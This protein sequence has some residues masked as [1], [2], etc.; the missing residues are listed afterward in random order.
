MHSA[1]YIAT[2]AMEKLKKKVFVGL[3]GGV[4][5]AVS[6]ALLKKDGYDVV[7]VFI[8][9]WSPDWLPCT[10]RED[11][12]D[13][14]RVA[15]VLNI[16]F[17]TLDLE[18]EYKEGV[19]DYMVSE[20]EAGRVPNPDVMCNKSVKFGAFLNFALKNGADLVATGHYAR[21]VKSQKVSACRQAGKV[22]G[23]VEK[24]E[25]QLLRGK[26]GNKDQSYFLWTLTQRRLEYILFPVGHMIKPEVRALAKKFNLPVA[27]KKDSQG[28]CFVGKIDMKEFL[29]HFS[30][31]KNGGV[32]S[33]NGD[34]IGTHD[35]AFFYTIG[36]R[37]GF[38]ILKGGSEQTPY[39]VVAKDVAK[40]T[41]TVSRLPREEKFATCDVNLKYENWVSGE[42]PT[43]GIYTAK[44]RYRQED[45]ICHLKNNG[46]EAYV[47][48]SVP[49][50][51]AEGQSIVI[52]D[53]EICLGGGIIGKSE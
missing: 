13:A 42:R 24:S 28:L 35:G 52:F 8:K 11:R 53:G 6:A 44:F 37:H 31:K 36:Q 51:I 41:I 20:Y 3:S 21:I 27:E 38:Q 48:F 39:Y 7:G 34:I 40:N 19:V 14:M 47:H 25:Y 46:N 32:L 5:S 29:A 16:P 50:N 15:A 18:K 1:C 43:D 10:W 33:E 45:I 23:G 12:R 17:I 22:K 2:I 9:V 4:D 49:E 30:E 26:D